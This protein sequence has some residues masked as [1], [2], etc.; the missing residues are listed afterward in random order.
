MQGEIA[1]LIGWWARKCGFS[2]EIEP[3]RPFSETREHPDALI[4]HFADSRD[5]AI[6]FTIP[7]ATCPSNIHSAAMG[8]GLMAAASESNKLN[9]YNWRCEPLE[10]E[11]IGAAVE[12]I[13]ALGPG[14]HTIVD[15]LAAASPRSDFPGRSWACPSFKS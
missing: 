13:G 7:S 1:G 6:D 11:F 2:V 10:W 5:T 9:K 3:P 14:F 8:P 12:S 4:R 15:R